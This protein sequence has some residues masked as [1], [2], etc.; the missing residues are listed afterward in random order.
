MLSCMTLWM[1]EDPLCDDLNASSAVCIHF[2]NSCN[3]IIVVCIKS[4]TDVFKVE[5]KHFQESQWRGEV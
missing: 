4:Q 3:I 5:V 2:I 1:F